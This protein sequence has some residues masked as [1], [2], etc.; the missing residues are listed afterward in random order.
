MSDTFWGPDF[1]AL[2]HADPEIAAVVLGELDRLRSGLQLIASENFT[3]PA[4][5]AV[6]LGSA[7]T[8]KYAEGYPRQA[9]LR[10]QRASSTSI[11][12]LGNR[13]GQAAVRRGPRQRAAPLA[14]PTPTCAPYQARA[15][16]R[17][18]RS[19]RLSLDARRS[20]HPRLAGQRSVASCTTSCT[21]KRRRRAT[22]RHRLWTRCA[23][24]AL[25]APPENDR[26][27]RHDQLP[28]PARLLRRSS[29]IADEVGALFMFDA[30]HIASA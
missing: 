3:S 22:E 10:R 21:Y 15:S 25:R 12:A 2:Q 17:V 28:A 9:L 27:R 14:A 26:L 30:A 11:E 16:I 18:T 20:P 24:L 8:N 5:M 13:A 6:L 19:S 23:S 7:L 4:V 29:A 1:D